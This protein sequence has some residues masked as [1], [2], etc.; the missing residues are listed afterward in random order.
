MLTAVDNRVGW[1][2]MLP[3]GICQDTLTCFNFQTTCTGQLMGNGLSTFIWLKSI[4]SSI[5]RDLRL[6]AKY[7]V[8]W[9]KLLCPGDLNQ[10]WVL[11][12]Q[13]HGQTSLCAQMSGYYTQAQQKACN[14]RTSCSVSAAAPL[15]L[16][17][18]P[19]GRATGGGCWMGRHGRLH[20]LLCLAHELIVW[21]TED[22][23]E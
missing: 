23:A 19:W 4:S 7:L 9:F 1:G 21:L 20:R 11:R 2:W 3:H 5:W 13:L 10:F 8:N 18:L 6:K 14:P 16:P 22:K 17:G 15:S 12:A